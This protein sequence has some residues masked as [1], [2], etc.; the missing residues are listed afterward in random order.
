M[1]RTALVSATALSLM[2]SLGA[3]SAMAQDD[4]SAHVG[5]NVASKAKLDREHRRAVAKGDWAND[6]Y[7][8][9]SSDSLNQAQLQD[10]PATAPD[11]ASAP[12]TDANTGIASDTTDDSAVS[13]DNTNNNAVDDDTTTLPSSDTPGV[14][15]Q[16]QNS[17]G[18]TSMPSTS[19]EAMPQSDVPASTDATKDDTE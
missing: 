18:S 2:L 4:Q 12:M 13:N 11:M 9:R 17:D 19:T 7:D 15:I 3:A 6:P 14:S 5:T 1:T 16:Q 10:Q 8:S